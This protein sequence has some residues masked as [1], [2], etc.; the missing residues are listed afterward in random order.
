MIVK[1]L[2]RKIHDKINGEPKLIRHQEK[3]DVTRVTQEKPVCKV[4][5][6]L[7]GTT[8]LYESITKRESLIIPPTEAFALRIRLIYDHKPY[9][10]YVLVADQS[11]ETP[12]LVYINL[13]K[14]RTYEIIP[15]ISRSDIDGVVDSCTY[16]RA[17]FSY[18]MAVRLGSL[19][20]FIVDMIY[21]LKELPIFDT[22]DLESWMISQNTVLDYFC[23]SLICV[24]NNVT[25]TKKLEVY[26]HEDDV[27]VIPESVD[28]ILG[29]GEICIVR[30]SHSYMVEVS[31]ASQLLESIPIPG[32]GSAIDVLDCVNIKA[33]LHMPDGESPIITPLTF[34]KENDKK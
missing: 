15:G 8:A 23:A 3:I 34:R 12:G 5:M 16:V 32:G 20:R 1:N 6:S 26:S 17:E 29:S 27:L 14:S 30:A 21:G 9:S 13:I 18:G 2:C 33:Y 11:E 4:Q 25:P 10:E 19:K 31:T 7:I 24:T 28:K 22:R